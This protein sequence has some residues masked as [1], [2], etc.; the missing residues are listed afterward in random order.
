MTSTPLWHKNIALPDTAA[1]MALGAHLAVLLQAGDVVALHGTLGAGKTT[2]A[3][4]LIQT[5]AEAP[6][7]VPSPTFTLVQ[8]YTTPHGTIAHYDWYRLRHAD[9][10]YELGFTEDCAT[11]ITL[12]EWPER[13]P[14]LLPPTTLSLTLEPAPTG[15]MAH[16]SIP[17][18]WQG[19]LSDFMKI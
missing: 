18:I 9:E 14:A 11:S 4:S 7:A 15:R 13:A 5:L 1:T 10:V 2:F 19:K 17:P 6:I 3:R 12:V 8:H 16:M